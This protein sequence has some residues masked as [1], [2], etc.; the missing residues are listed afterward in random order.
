MVEIFWVPYHRGHH[1]PH[2][3]V[4]GGQRYNGNPIYICRATVKG[5]LCVG[6]FYPR[7]EIA[8]IP[9]GGEEH[10]FHSCEILVCREAEKLAWVPMSGGKTPYGAITGGHTK[11]GK[12]L[13]VGRVNVRHEVIPGKIY[14]DHHRIYICN[15]GKEQ[16][17]Y[18][19]EALAIKQVVPRRRYHHH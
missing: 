13:F 7:R 4:E 15:E 10:V 5:E 17:Y 6:K 8:K 11:H 14:P 12:T 2:H 3:M 9:Y 18:H 16:N 1:V 19:Y